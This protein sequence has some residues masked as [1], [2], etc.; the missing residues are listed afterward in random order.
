VRYNGKKVPLE[1]KNGKAFVPE[2]QE[3]Q[4]VELGLKQDGSKNRYGVVLKVN[5]ENTLEKERLPDLT[6]HKWVL[7]PG[8]G[9]WAIRGYQVGD[10]LEKFRVA[11]IAESGSVLALRC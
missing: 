10:V 5:G 2:P 6:C 11:S 9:P 4:T 8:Y 3:G 1:L 7:D